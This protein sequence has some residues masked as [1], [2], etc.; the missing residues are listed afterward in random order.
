MYFN[1]FDH[2]NVQLTCIE[3]VF[4]TSIKFLCILSKYNPFNFNPNLP[5]TL[6]L[7]LVTKKCHEP[8]KQSVGRKEKN[9]GNHCLFF[10]PH[11]FYPF[12]ANPPD[13]SYFQVMI[14]QEVLS[15]IY[16]VIKF[17]VL[18]FSQP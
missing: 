16:R 3:K 4:G 13:F 5:V 14:L 17:I 1:Q 7:K 11:V 2:R 8:R 18:Q 15:A 6:A 9:A 12:A 10:C